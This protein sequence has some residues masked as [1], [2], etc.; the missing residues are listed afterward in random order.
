LVETV[1]VP[2][3][4]AP[5]ITASTSFATGEKY[6]VVVSGTA[7]ANEAIEFDAEYS[8]NQGVNVGDKSTATWTNGVL[9]YPSYGEN[10]LDLIMNGNHINWGAYNSGH[11]YTQ[12]LTGTGIPPNFQF[13]IDDF[14][15]YNDFGSLTVKIYQWML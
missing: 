6:K 3:L 10:C 7:W 1:T 14:A 12:Y 13:Q 4:N 9:G 11:T 8:W 15:A 5:V 2:A